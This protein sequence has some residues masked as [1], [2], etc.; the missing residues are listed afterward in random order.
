MNEDTNMSET[1]KSSHDAQLRLGVSTCLLG[2]LVRYDGGHKL[3]RY[4]VNT[5]GV[6]VEWVQV[7]PEVEMAHSPKHY[8]QMGRLVADAGKRDWDELSAE[9]GAQFMEG[10]GVMGTRGKHVNVLQH[11]MGY[12]KNHISSEDKQELLGLIQDYRQG[13]VPLIVPITLLKHH[14]GRY[15]VPEWVYQQVYLNPYPKE[16]MLRNH[17]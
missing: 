15:P 10:F 11:L 17:V 16:L 3:D 1:E 9:Y 2:E 14:L 5:L 13:L 7:C 6:F 12:L 8:T 4:L